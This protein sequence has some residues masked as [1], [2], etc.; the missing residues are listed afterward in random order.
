MGW[1]LTI[2]I[3]I[4]AIIIKFFIDRDNMLKR[5][6]DSQG[7]MKV[8]YQYLIKELSHPQTPQFA[9][10]RRD[11]IHL[12]FPGNPTAINYYITEQ[13]NKVEVHWLFEGV[14]LGNFEHKWLFPQ[15]MPQ[16]EMAEQIAIDLAKKHEQIF[17][18]D[19]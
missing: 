17:G 12:R 18:G 5:Q 16:K 1:T 19:I 6:V 8:K 14:M 4:I 9:Q 7:G 11:F 10:V 3:I 13:Y 15:T 2:C